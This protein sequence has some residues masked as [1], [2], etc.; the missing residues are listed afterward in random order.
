MKTE[1]FLHNPKAKEKLKK[2][3]KH[4]QFNLCE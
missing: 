4:Q 2:D 1:V 3:Y